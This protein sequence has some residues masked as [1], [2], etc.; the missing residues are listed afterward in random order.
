MNRLGTTVIVMV[1]ATGSTRGD[2]GR[3]EAWSSIDGVSYK[4]QIG[5]EDIKAFPSWNPFKD[6]CPLSPAKAV[7]LALAELKR[8]SPKLEMKQVTLDFVTLS[9]ADEDL[10]D[11]WLYTLNFWLSE[12]GE[13]GPWF[14][15]HVCLDGT[16][17]KLQKVEKKTPNQ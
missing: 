17:P 2:D 16:V 8:V 10:R 14:T 1:L 15:V 7:A 6:P 13:D 12:R 3:L 5:D 11:K 9:K 4:Q